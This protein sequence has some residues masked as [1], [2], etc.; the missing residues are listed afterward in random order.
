MIEISSPPSPTEQPKGVRQREHGRVSMKNTAPGVGVSNPTR[1]QHAELSAVRSVHPG[2]SGHCGISDD[3][4]AGPL[5]LRLLRFT[6]LASSGSLDR[7]ILGF[8]TSF[9]GIYWY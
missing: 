5:G 1:V 3:C 2:L 4:H 8:A 9:I 7:H 6:R